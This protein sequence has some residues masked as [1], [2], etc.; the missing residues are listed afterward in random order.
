MSNGSIVARGG[1]RAGGVSA[2]D[3]ASSGPCCVQYHH[4]CHRWP[5]LEGNIA[6]RYGDATDGLGGDRRGGVGPNLS[7]CRSGWASLSRERGVTWSC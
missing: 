6:L 2:P 3:L 4:Y 5:A 7:L 1:S